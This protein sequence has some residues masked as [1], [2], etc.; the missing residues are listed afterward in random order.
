MCDHSYVILALFLASSRGGGEPSSKG[1]SREFIS[2]L[3]LSNFPC[4]PYLYLAMTGG[5]RGVE[6]ALLMIATPSPPAVVFIAGK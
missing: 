2:M 3:P 4:V 6:C 1:G 5:E